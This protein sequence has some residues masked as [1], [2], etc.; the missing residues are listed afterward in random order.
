MKQTNV[1]SD[2]SYGKR[3][4]EAEKLISTS[5]QAWA[6]SNIHRLSKGRIVIEKSRARSSR[7][8]GLALSHGLVLHIGITSLHLFP[9][10]GNVQ[11]KSLWNEIMKLFFEGV[12]SWAIFWCMV[13]FFSL[14]V[15]WLFFGENI[16]WKKFVEIK[17][18]NRIAG[19]HLLSFFPIAPSLAQFFQPFFAVQEFWG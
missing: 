2:Q 4:S 11:E 14:F 3:N 5:A 10:D 7:S 17:H 9:L 12:G 8:C 18:R 1:V 6:V 13:F 15:A 16:L 19:K